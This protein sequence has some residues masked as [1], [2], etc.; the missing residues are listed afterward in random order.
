[1]DLRQWADNKP[2]KKGISLP[3]VRWKQLVDSS[4]YIDEALKKDK[5]FQSHLGG[6]LY[7]S[8]RENYPCMDIRQFWKPEEEI[9]P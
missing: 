4:E 9:V 3:L 8:V 7:C 5:P 1:M 2:T 6:N